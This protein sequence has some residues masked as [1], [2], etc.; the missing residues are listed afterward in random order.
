MPYLM[1]ENFSA[2]IDL[3]KSWLTAP[4]GTLRDLKNAVIT[5]GGEIQKRKTLTSLGVFPAETM[6]LGWLPTNHTAVTFGTVAEASLTG[7]L[8]P[9]TTYHRLT[10]PGAALPVEI[11]DVQ[12]FQQKLY[13]VARMDDGT[14]KHFYDGAAV[15]DANAKGSV[16]RAFKSKLYALDAQNLRFSKLLTATDWTDTLSGAGVI[17]L[18]T[19]DGGAIDG[20]GLEEYF[21]SLAVFGRTSV[22]VWD[23]DPDPALSTLRQTLGGV[24]LMAPQ[25]LARFG[26]GDVLFLSDT[27]IRSLRVRDNSLSASVN[28]VGAPID[29]LVIARRSAFDPGIPGA[30][31]K[32]VGL[33]DPLTGNFWLTWGTEAFVLAHYPSS[34]I[35]AWSRFDFGPDVETAVVCGSR[36]TLRAAN[37]LLIYGSYVTGQ[38]PFS[39][40]ATVAPL[41]VVSEDSSE[42]VIE[43]PFMDAGS[44][45]DVKDWRGIDLSCAGTWEI[46]VCVDPM[47]PEGN[48]RSWTYLGQ[49]T[50]PTWPLGRLPIEMRSTH[51]AFKLVN[52]TAEAASVAAVALHYNPGEAG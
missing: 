15:V 5:A 14:V 38:N 25:A 43:T 29:P 36:V 6:G 50:G 34:K 39:P 12:L 45:A 22:Q 8:P 27:G 10:P 19:A 35:S 48:P 21:G 18:T 13:V 24:G 4:P 46:H 47:I 11:L 28:D 32:L 7:P 20:V 41:G 9:Y 30:A 49:I 17:D 26:S 40:N 31:G 37:E 44:P 3:R 2:G 52:R 23:M 1:I 51:I 33:V 42:V 16:I